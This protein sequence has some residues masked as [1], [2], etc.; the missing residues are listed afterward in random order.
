MYPLLCIL[1]SCLIAFTPYAAPVGAAHCQTSSTTRSN[2]SQAEPQ[3]VTLISRLGHKE[4][5]LGKSAFNF[6]HGLRSD[7]EQFTHNHVDLLYGSWSISG[8]SDWFCVS[9]GGE[10]PSKIKDL[11][12]LEWSDLERVPV[13]LATPPTSTGIRTPLAGESYEDSTEQRVAKAIAGH[14]YIVHMKDTESDIY[15]M[16]RVERLNPSDNCVITWKLVASPE[17]E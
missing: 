4:V 15:A 16:F 2:D 17:K 14:L 13:L 8:N 1:L 6:E 7:S 3:E 5:G 9:S 11:G 12:A 10:N